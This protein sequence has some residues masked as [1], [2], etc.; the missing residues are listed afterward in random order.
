MALALTRCA[1]SDQT[2]AHSFLLCC[3]CRQLHSASRLS[4]NEH[5]PPVALDMSIQLWHVKEES[6]AC[7]M[8]H[9]NGRQTCWQGGQ[10]S[11]SCDNAGLLSRHAAGQTWAGM[12]SV[13]G[14]QPCRQSM[15]GSSKQ[16][17]IL[18]GCPWYVQAPD[19]DADV[20]VEVLGCLATLSIPGFDWQPIIDKNDLVHFLTGL[21][22][23]CTE[24]C[25]PLCNLRMHAKL[26]GC[27]A[28]E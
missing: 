15:Q 9:C 12:H 24:L 13:Q 27:W 21:N 16:K 8:W 7:C 20:F 25:T 18:R 4:S 10:T 3:P 11:Q 19:I 17:S 1:S 2:W 14:R 23:T 26:P 28:P 22:Q 6:E 5:P